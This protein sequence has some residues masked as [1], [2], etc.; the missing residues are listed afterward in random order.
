MR[1][2]TRTETEILN[3]MRLATPEEQVNT[4]SP[5]VLIEMG[6]LQETAEF[7]EDDSIDNVEIKVTLQLG[8]FEASSSNLNAVKHILNQLA[9]SL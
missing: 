7:L 2:I 5:Y 1:N 9:G 6:N 4:T 8:N 3:P